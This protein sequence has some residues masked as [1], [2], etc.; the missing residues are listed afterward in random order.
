LEKVLLI[1]QRREGGN[2]PKMDFLRGK[3]I[4]RERMEV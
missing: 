3:G 1:L 2:K 4:G